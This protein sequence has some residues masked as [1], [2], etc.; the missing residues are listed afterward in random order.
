VRAHPPRRCPIEVTGSNSWLPATGRLLEA[1]VRSQGSVRNKPGNPASTRFCA[2]LALLSVLHRELR[3][4]RPRQGCGGNLA[5][6]EA[7]T[8]S[9]SEASQQPRLGGSKIPIEDVIEATNP[10]RL[11]V[12]L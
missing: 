3:R 6:T 11:R 2:H 10:N 12:P 4:V 9:T 8:P 1:E 5:R 7:H